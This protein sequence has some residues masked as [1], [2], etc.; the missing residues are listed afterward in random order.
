ML[1]RRMLLVNFLHQPNSYI[2]HW[3][4]T[5]PISNPNSVPKCYLE[6]N[7]HNG[8]LHIWLHK[9]C[10]YWKTSLTKPPPP[11]GAVIAI[12]ICKIAEEDVDYVSL[13]IILGNYVFTCWELLH[14]NL[15]LYERLVKGNNTHVGQQYWL[16]YRLVWIPENFALTGPKVGQNLRLVEDQIY[17]MLFIYIILCKCFRICCLVMNSCVY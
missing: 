6:P 4:S 7:Y 1:Q 9:S 12:V 10:N 13:K 11:L 17:Q 2:Q 16:L 3:T 14:I 15:C 8:T 5:V